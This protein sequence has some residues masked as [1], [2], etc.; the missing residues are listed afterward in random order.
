M[1]FAQLLLQLLGQLMHPRGHAMG[2]LAHYLNLNLQYRHASFKH[3]AG[4][5]N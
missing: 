4:C 5:W 3:E 2:W 1:L